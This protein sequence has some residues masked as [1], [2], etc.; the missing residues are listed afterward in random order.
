[1]QIKKQR[2]YTIIDGNKV[3]LDIA[4]I[5]LPSHFRSTKHFTLSTPLGVTGDYNAVKTGRNFI[6][7]DKPDNLIKSG[8]AYSMADHDV[9]GDV[10]HEPI[11]ISNDGFVLIDDE[12]YESLMQDD[13]IKQEL[14][15]KTVFRYKGDPTTAIAMAL[16]SHGALPTKCILPEGI[17]SETLSYDSDLRDIMENSIKDM[18]RENGLF[19]D[20]SHAG[21]LS[22]EGGH[23][24]NY[25]DDKN[26]DHFYAITEFVTF[27]REKFPEHAE[28]LPEFLRLDHR[29]DS[30][31]RLD[32]IIEGIGAQNLI[33]AIGE[34]NA[35]TIE[36][37][38]QSFKNYK[39]E[40][41][42]ITPEM[43]DKFVGTIAAINDYYKTPEAAYNY[44]IE[45]S[46]QTFLQ[47]KSV[48]EQSEAADTVLTMLGVTKNALSD[49]RVGFSD[50]EAAR[51]VEEVTQTKDTL[52]LE[53][54]GYTNDR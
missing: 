38:D 10:S 36:K 20:K 18:A 25:Y 45:P 17:R 9:Y 48:K 12:K 3:P 26:K 22:P 53:N 5:M 54:E 31:G 52:D 29:D 51:R 47:G 28:L 11:K 30:L 13:E 40:R 14:E 50:L 4:D 27:L 19:Y 46:I 41:R 23:F 39:E 6:V 33:D 2:N 1:M 35:K 21:K 44:D 7:F 24:S 15:G 43:H 34:Y 8:Y 16:A 32:K 49:K 37:M 42:N